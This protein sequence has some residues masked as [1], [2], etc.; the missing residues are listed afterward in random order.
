MT[1]GLMNLVAAGQTNIILNGNPRKSFWKTTFKSY[2]NFGMQSFRLDYTGT[3]ALSL[4]T[5]ST[6]KFVVKRYAD[7][8]MDAY[9]VIQLPTI[10]SPIYPPV[11]QSD[12]TYSNWNPYEFKWIDNLGSQI[13]QSVTVT[14]GNQ[15]LQEFSGRYLLASV[16]R[17]FSG[18]KKQ[19]FDEMT[20][21]VTELNDPANY[22]TNAG[23]YPNAYFTDSPAGAQPSINAR[24]LTVPLNAWFSYSTTQTFPLV[25]LQYNEL[26]ITVTLRPVNEWFTIKDVTNPVNADKDVAPNF[27]N[28][29][30]QL[31]HFLQTPPNW[32]LQYD[33]VRT[34]WNADIHLSSTYCFLSNDEQAIFA[35]NNH[36]YFFKQ[37]REY[38]F[39]N[40]TGQNKI[41]LDSNGMV[42][43]WM[44]TLQRSDINLRNQWSNYTNWPYSTIPVGST[45]APIQGMVPIQ[46]PDGIIYIGPGINPDGTLTGFQITPVYTP[47]NLKTILV[48]MGIL[49]DGQYRENTLPF[50]FFNQIQKYARTEGNAP[51]GLC[52]YNFCVTTDPFS[53]QPSGAMNVSRFTNVQ[54]ELST[55]SPPA[56]PYAQVL[57]VCNPDTGDIVAINKP[58]WRIYMYNYNMTVFEE[59]ANFIEIKGGNAGV[60][61]AL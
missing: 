37:I 40:V 22:N 34:N 50:N 17:D 26:T 18:Q 55:I 23:Q 57:T 42:L 13:I 36:T 33:N 16:Q 47:A 20:G 45:D 3:P 58:T 19:L 31:Y 30:M 38:Q 28:E 41:D 52:C 51:D 21:N 12:G 56:D 5:E 2:T 29:S 25:A 6:Y 53:T 32:A 46:E 49:M 27:N 8:L 1:G 61:Y 7:L 10:W 54:F 9:F 11:K 4:N 24:T 48:S 39:Y 44:F 59:R 14:C 35:Q 60:M 15:K 43:S